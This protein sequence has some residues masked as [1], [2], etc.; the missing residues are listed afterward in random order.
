M[1]SIFLMMFAMSAPVSSAVFTSTSRY[2]TYTVEYEMDEESRS[3]ET[4]EW[5]VCFHERIW[6]IAYDYH[7]KTCSSRSK[8]HDDDEESCAV[9]NYFPE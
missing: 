1:V 2:L 6:Y 9:A 3:S 8:E 4:K 5:K 7:E